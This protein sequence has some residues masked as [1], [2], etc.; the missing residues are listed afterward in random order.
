MG[1][2]IKVPKLPK[3]PKLPGLDMA[4]NL[5]PKMPELPEMP[6][7]AMPEMPEM[8]EIPEVPEMPK[9]PSLKAPKMPK[10]LGGKLGS[11]V[12]G[13]DVGGG[14]KNKANKA[15][16]KAKSAIKGRGKGDKYKREKETY[17]PSYF[18]VEI[19]GIQTARFMRCD[20]LEAETYIYEVEEG[21]L[22]NCTH[23]FIGRTRFPNIILENG[24][25][26]NNDLYKWHKETTMTDKKIKRKNGSIVMYNSKG[27][28][29]KRWNFYKA[30]P[31]RWV[32][33]SLGHDIHGVAIEKIEIAHEGLE[34]AR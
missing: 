29:I 3:L 8:P 34:L 1:F 18:G 32:G 13:K 5:M 23:K 9:V 2:K 19:E 33:P 16:K 25:T 28:E 22:N 24:I 21:G 31:C 10:G 30:I 12:S 6:E 27:D 20:G 11:K 7:L 17:V 4:K 26:S 14:L 15:G